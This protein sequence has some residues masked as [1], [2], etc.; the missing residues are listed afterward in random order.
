MEISDDLIE[1]TDGEYQFLSE[2]FDIISPN[3]VYELP[4][5][6]VTSK[7]DNMKKLVDSAI[8]NELNETE[9][10]Y[11]REKFF[12]NLTVSEISRKYNVSRQSVYRSLKSAGKRLYDVLKYAYFCGFSLL[13]P[14]QNFEELLKTTTKGEL[15]ENH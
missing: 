8:R 14:P 13:N 12:N 6:I 4:L 10:I 1:I 3:E 2:K 9:G 11:V 15:Y 7:K 5:Y